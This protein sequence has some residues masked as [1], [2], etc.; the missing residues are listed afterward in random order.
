M[1]DDEQPW[2]YRPRHPASGWAA[3]SVF[4]QKNPRELFLGESIPLKQN[5]A[6]P[7]SEKLALPFKRLCTVEVCVGPLDSYA[8]YV[9]GKKKDLDSPNGVYTLELEHFHP[10]VIFLTNT[11]PLAPELDAKVELQR[12]IKDKE[13]VVVA[14]ATVPIVWSTDEHSALVLPPPMA[15]GQI[16][17]EKLEKQARPV[18]KALKRLTDNTTKIEEYGKIEDDDSKDSKEKTES[19]DAKNLENFKTRLVETLLAE[20]AVLKKAK[21]NEPQREDYEII[22]IELH[23]RTSTR[24]KQ[25]KFQCTTNTY[26]HKEI[27]ARDQ[28]LVELGTLDSALEKAGKKDQHVSV[29]PPNLGDIKEKR[30]DIKAAYTVVEW[31]T[32]IPMQQQ[33]HK[34]FSADEVF[35]RRMQAVDV[36]I[37]TQIKELQG[38]SIRAFRLHSLKPPSYRKLP[39]KSDIA[40]LI[41]MV[42]ANQWLRCP[43]ATSGVTPTS[44]DALGIKDQHSMRATAAAKA[45]LA[46]L[47]VF[48]TVLGPHIFNYDK[49]PS[50]SALDMLHGPPRRALL[51]MEKGVIFI[52]GYILPIG[53]TPL[54]FGVHDSHNDLSFLS[55][56]GSVAKMLLRSCGSWMGK[57]ISVR[58]RNAGVKRFCA[59]LKR[60]HALYTSEKAP[61]VIQL[62]FMPV[63]TLWANVPKIDLGEKTP[64]DGVPI[65]SVAMAMAMTAIQNGNHVWNSTARTSQVIAAA[66]SMWRVYT[67]NAKS[68][69]NAIFAIQSGRPGAYFPSNDQKYIAPS[70]VAK[71]MRD[72]YL[73]ADQALHA[74]TQQPSSAAW[75]K[76]LHDTVGNAWRSRLIH[77]QPE[78]LDMEQMLPRA[79]PTKDEVFRYTIPPGAPARPTRVHEYM[80]AYSEMPVWLSGMQIE[81]ESTPPPSFHMVI[82]PLSRK[83]AYKSPPDPCMFDF[84]IAKGKAKLTVTFLLAEAGD[85]PVQLGEEDKRGDS[86]ELAVQNTRHHNLSGVIERARCVMWNAERLVQLSMLGWAIGVD[87]LVLLYF[88]QSNTDLILAAELAN[89]ATEASDGRTLRR[90]CMTKAHI[91]EKS[92]LVQCMPLSEAAFSFLS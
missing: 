9:D 33:L 46:E 77:P 23:D 79:N 86:F 65:I 10:V 71:F 53:H 89:G 68:T 58:A 25:F 50:N 72:D 85:E 4:K 1:S 63:Q 78:M 62:P 12:R 55:P 56:G 44:I 60:V 69:S 90:I 42:D 20:I 28:T 59:A 35:N 41:P 74:N 54:A 39:L 31:P 66:T 3:T 57:D 14:E 17:T 49:L 45:A 27:V 38:Q 91:R 7:S 30:E 13:S 5:D 76:Y 88:P 73:A 34:T 26:T 83:D 36:E 80:P 87:E 82:Q 18:V 40:E 92:N 51:A 24:K 37:K 29:N 61:P 16:D 52:E 6:T 75:R 47:V 8:V 22:S 21:D 64:T 2:Q 15:P 67:A 19:K 81:K 84:R 48:E 70:D 43:L 32:L 11:S